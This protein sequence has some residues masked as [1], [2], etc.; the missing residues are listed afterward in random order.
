[1]IERTLRH[2]YAQ[3][4]LVAHLQETERALRSEL[5][6]LDPRADCEVVPA[7]DLGIPYDAL[8]LSGGFATGCFVQWQC[9]VPIVPVDITMNIDT[10][11]I[12]WVSE[13]AESE[14]TEANLTRVRSLI[15]S[16]TGYEWNLDASNHFISLTR[17]ETSGRLAVIVHSNEKEFKNQ[18]NGLCPTVD[19]WF[20]R[21]IRVSKDGRIRLII[22]RPAEVFV[23][24]A[25]MLEPFNVSRHRFII[26][27][28]LG[29]QVE[30]FEESH[31]HHYFMPSGSSAALGCYIVSPGDRVPIFSQPGLPILMYEASA[32]G[33]NVVR[34]AG[35][36]RCVLPHGWGMGLS[37]PLS[38]SIHRNHLEFQGRLYP[39]EPGVSLLNDP[40]V[41]RREFESI[42]AFL[43]QI[44]PLSPGRAVGTFTQLASLT[45]LGFRTH[46]VTDHD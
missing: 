5:R 31:T 14:F 34:V 30:V 40:S 17:D 38:M 24:V 27:E 37:E 43:D 42:D 15:E 1:M 45:R 33:P 12:F 41:T 6:E 18:Y 26:H 32:G 21:N 8:R 2:D 35:Q 23:D 39:R 9:T 4:G 28:L 3:K 44:S 29:E 25:K 36:D 20:D 19:N 11:S 16:Q 22:G 7:V 13:G 10:S 46:G